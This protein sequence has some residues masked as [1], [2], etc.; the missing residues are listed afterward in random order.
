MQHIVEVQMEVPCA[1]PPDAVRQAVVTVL[2]QAGV[3]QSCEVAVV[4]SDDETLQ[5]LN[6]R[7]RG[8]D[9][10]TDVLS[11]AD[12]TRGPFSVVGEL[13]YLGDIVISVERAEAQAQAAGGTLTQEIQVL[14]VH[15]TLHLL[16]HDHA[17]PE[18]KARMWAAQAAALQHL[19]AD[20]RLP[21]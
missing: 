5:S 16:G 14:A 11:F 6:R 18:D 1:V 17:T 4:L 21:E 2:Q 19:G 3:E 7:F 13:R 9:R 20:I 10:P 12:D 15:G 8:V